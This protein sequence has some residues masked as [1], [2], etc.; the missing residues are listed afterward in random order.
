MLYITVTAKEQWDQKTETFSSL[1]KDCTLELEHSLISIFKWECKHHKPYLDA[2]VEKTNEE[3]LDYIRCMTI[4]KNVDPKAYEFLSKENIQDI[5]DYI[6]DPHSAT[7]FNDNT[8]GGKI[9]ASKMRRETLTAELIYYYMGEYGICWEAQKWHINNLLTLINIYSVK[10]S[11]GKK[12]SK[13]D[14][15]NRNSELN[16]ARRMAMHS[17][18]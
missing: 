8:S 7:W 5:H 17:K 11:D 4:N 1:D 9:R 3:I 13:K 10:N 12:M 18:G 16:K 14:I 15:I 6:N 2:T